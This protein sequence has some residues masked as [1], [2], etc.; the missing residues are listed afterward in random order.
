MTRTKRICT[1]CLIILLAIGV[2]IATHL[3]WNYF[4]Q[5]SHQKSYEEIVKNCS[6]EYDVPEHLIFSVI[7]VESDFDPYARS[8]VGA[9]GLMQ[10]MPSTFEW[11]TGEEHLNEN[12]SA[13]RLTDPEVSIRYGT[14]Y[15]RYLYLKFGN[16]D[17]VLAAYNGGEGNVAKWL[18]D[19]EYSDG[20]GNLTYIPFEE[21]RNYVKKVNDAMATYDK[22]NNQN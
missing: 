1:V 14:Y 3:L 13:L 8:S 9:V 6:E 18:D 20:Q 7:K 15:L 21:T 10:M 17:T 12:L 16:W 5:K 2:G 11:L 19:P 22:Q 4:D